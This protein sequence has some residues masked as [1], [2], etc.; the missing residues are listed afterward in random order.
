MSHYILLPLLVSTGHAEVDG[1]A[2]ILRR[3]VGEQGL[4]SYRDIQKEEAA[5]VLAQLRDAEIPSGEEGRKAFW[6][7]AYNAITIATVVAEH[8]MHGHALVVQ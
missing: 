4:V 3:T 5:A 6:I 1:Y 8:C 7:N 2:E